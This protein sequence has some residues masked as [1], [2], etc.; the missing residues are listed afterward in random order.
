MRRVFTAVFPILFAD[1][2]FAD[3]LFADCFFA[4]R[5]FA[6]MLVYFVALFPSIIHFNSFY[7]QNIFMYFDYPSLFS[8][9]NFLIFVSNTLKKTNLKNSSFHT[10]GPLFTNHRTFSGTYKKLH[11][12]NSIQFL[13]TLIPSSNYMT[14]EVFNAF[15]PRFSDMC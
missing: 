5:L 3:R 10:S 7:V 15:L 1:R 14:Y 12:F 6:A 2:L 9:R 13:K 8:S 11:F 4:D